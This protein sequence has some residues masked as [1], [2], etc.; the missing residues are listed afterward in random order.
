MTGCSFRVQG[1]QTSCWNICSLW[2]L[3]PLFQHQ[4]PSSCGSNATNPHSDIASLRA[5]SPFREA[6]PPTSIAAVQVKQKSL[7]TGNYYDKVCVHPRRLTIEPE[8]DGLEG[9]LPFP[10]GPYSQ[11]LAVNLP[12]AYL[13]IPSQHCR[14]H[15]RD[16]SVDLLCG[17]PARSGVLGTVN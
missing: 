7:S 16:F 9:D 5:A 15:C 2:K 6:E 10:G 8:N 11:V 1:N 4:T 14:Q 17:E 12:G 13:S 3:S